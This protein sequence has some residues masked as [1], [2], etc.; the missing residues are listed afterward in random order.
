MWTTLLVALLAST[1]HN[2]AYGF[3][4]PYRPSTVVSSTGTKSLVSDVAQA[5]TCSRR[6]VNGV[7]L[8]ETPDG[9]DKSG[10][11]AAAPKEEEKKEEPEF[12]T[13]AST[14]GLF[15][16]GFSDQFEEKKKPEPPKKVVEE[17]KPAPPPKVQEKKSEPPKKVAEETKPEPVVAAAAKSPTKVIAP[18]K[19]ATPTPPR[20]PRDLSEDVSQ[21]IVP[22]ISFPKISLPSFGGGGGGEKKKASPPKAPKKPTSTEDAI[23]SALGGAVAG[24]AAGI[25]TDIATDFL[26]DT[27]LPAILPP[28]ALGIALG[29]AAYV[30]ATQDNFLGSATKVVFGGPVIGVKNSITNKITETVDDI[31]ATPGKI[32]DAAV[33]KVEDT[34]DDIKATPGKIK[35]G[36]VKKVDETVDEIKVC[37]FIKD[38]LECSVF[39]M[40]LYNIMSQ[41]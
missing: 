3:S 23:A 2:Q 36:V 16:P 41:L 14:E 33:K 5:W 13:E 35:D 6:S 27:D 19:P 17:K 34:V 22:D 1:S 21:S 24:A 26:F 15:I 28:A 8:Y 39:S 31:K 10:E 38:F 25:Y 32:K 30:G 40:I 11:E 20:P 12:E 18:K 9:D 37:F 7:C 4:T 29:T